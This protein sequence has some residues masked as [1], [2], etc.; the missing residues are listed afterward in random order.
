MGQVVP[1]DAGEV[2]AF[3][4]ALLESRTPKPVFTL[5]AATRR[6]RR[7]FRR[8][9]IQEGGVRH[10]RYAIREEIFT[11]CRALWDDDAAEREIPRLKEFFEAADDHDKAMEEWSKEAQAVHAANEGVAKSKQKKLPGAPLFDHPDLAAF[12]ELEQS[13]V[14]AWPPLRRMLADN[15]SADSVLPMCIGAVA[16]GGWSGVE[17]PYRRT[18]EG[19]PMETMEALADELAETAAGSFAELMGAC[20]KRLFLDADTE[21]N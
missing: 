17:T 11:A 14:A 13:I 19:V 8:L 6:D 5:K 20:S 9:T 1:M 18:A 21:K 16:L 12:Q 4:P 2:E 15:D 3:T 7:L 10:S